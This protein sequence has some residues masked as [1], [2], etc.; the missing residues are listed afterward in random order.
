MASVVSN[1]NTTNKSRPNDEQQRNKP[2]EKL[3]NELQTALAT[4]D[5][6]D[7]TI[8]EL[9]VQ[10][11]ALVRDKEGLT[12][13][14]DLLKKFLDSAKRMDTATEKLTMAVRDKIDS[15]EL[16]REGLMVWSVEMGNGMA[17][18]MYRAMDHALGEIQ[19]QFDAQV[20]QQKEYIKELGEEV[21]KL[22]KKFV[23]FFALYGFLFLGV[24]GLV[25][26]ILKK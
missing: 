21:T 20:H 8:A 9:K 16:L 4:I 10:N 15:D 26:F 13:Q 6:Q 7:R 1:R 24:M 14:L 3:S 5:Q 18:K 25:V 12:E 17:D 22:K 23:R 11:V 19:G 2:T